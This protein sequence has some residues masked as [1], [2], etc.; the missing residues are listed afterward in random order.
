MLMGLEQCLATQQHIRMA[1]GASNKG[2]S[3]MF[4]LEESDEVFLCDLGDSTGA[5]GKTMWGSL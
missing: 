2:L 5:E 3:L 1:C 4:T